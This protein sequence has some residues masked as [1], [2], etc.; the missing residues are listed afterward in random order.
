MKDVMEIQIG[1]AQTQQRQ[2]VKMKWDINE[3]R[4]PQLLRFPF[5]LY[6]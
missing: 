1:V 6:L 4:E 2:V 5:I 3:K